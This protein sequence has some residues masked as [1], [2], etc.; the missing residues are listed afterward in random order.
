VQVSPQRAPGAGER[1]ERKRNRNRYVNPDLGRR[2][3]MKK[4]GRTGARQGRRGRYG[5]KYWY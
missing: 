5:Y 3:M 2:E 4:K 1:E